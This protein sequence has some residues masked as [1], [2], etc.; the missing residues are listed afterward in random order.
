MCE[1][2]LAIGI[3]LKVWVIDSIWILAHW[4]V[5]LCLARHLL[6]KFFSKFKI[7]PRS[8]LP[9]IFRMTI[10]E[11][12]SNFYSETKYFYH[13]HNKDFHLKKM[14]AQQRLPLHMEY[15]QP[16]LTVSNNHSCSHFVEV[17][18]F[19]LWKIDLA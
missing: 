14:L 6:I 2:L 5:L 8:H 18:I 9:F 15:L 17:K 4:I 11:G 19:S 10:R 1:L 16:N 3:L 13:N 7:Y 12:Q